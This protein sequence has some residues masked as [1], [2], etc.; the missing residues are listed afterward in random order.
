MLDGVLCSEAGRIG[1]E[2][3]YRGASGCLVFASPLRNS[4]YMSKQSFQQSGDKETGSHSKS[5]SL[6][7][8]PGFW[9]NY[10]TQ[11][12]KGL[13]GPGN[14]LCAYGLQVTLGLSVLTS[15]GSQE[16]SSRPS[17]ANSAYAE[18]SVA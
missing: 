7:T 5:C 15:R 13:K 14:R 16:G 2:S 8:I 1:R 18:G 11:S 10:S 17:S 12:L 9:H 3:G 4:Y 6:C